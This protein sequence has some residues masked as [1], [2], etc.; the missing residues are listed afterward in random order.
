MGEALGRLLRP[1]DV[2]ALLGELG[3]GKTVLVRGLATGLGCAPMEVHSPSFTLVNE[4]GC[5]PGEGDPSRR[6]VPGCLAHL[7]LYRLQSEDEIPGIGWDEYVGSRH[8]AVVEWAE[9]ALPWLPPDHLRVGLEVTGVH[10]RR[11]RVEPTGPRSWQLLRDW[12]EMAGISAHA[13]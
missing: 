13:G 9:R 8:V 2:V 7:D 11:I 1:G 4:Y 3:S 6:R 5:R 10:E 12:V